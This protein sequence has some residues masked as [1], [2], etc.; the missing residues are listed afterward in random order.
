VVIATVG[1]QPLGTLARATGLAR[2]RPDRVDE[3]QQF[4]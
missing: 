3:G 4:G 2:Q 1:K